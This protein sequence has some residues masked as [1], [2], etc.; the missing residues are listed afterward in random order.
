MTRKGDISFLQTTTYSIFILFDILLGTT[1][2]LNL[3]A[4]SV[5]RMFAVKF[6]TRHFNLSWR[7]VATA[8]SITW[9]MGVTSAGIKFIP[10]L[11]LAIYTYIIFSLAFLLPTAVIIASYIILYIAAK[12]SIKQTSRRVTKEVRVARMIQVII[13]LYLFCWLPFFIL[14]VIYFNCEP[15]CD[16]IPYSL[17]FFTKCLHYSNS[18]MNFFVYALRSPEFRNSFRALLFRHPLKRRRGETYSS[19]SDPR[20]RTTSNRSSVSTGNN[21]DTSTLETPLP[22][23]R[24]MDTTTI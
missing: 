13:G 12:E 1:S 19:D 9:F 22:L 14:N 8:I 7:P 21:N 20:K 6:P 24:D 23:R 2:I 10:E 17:F 11:T 5:E 18:M 15:W 3:M 4:V 16:D